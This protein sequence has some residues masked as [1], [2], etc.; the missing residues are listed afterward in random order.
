VNRVIVP[1]SQWIFEKI[2]TSAI[3]QDALA[4]GPEDVLEPQNR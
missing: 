2:D 4:V 3:G 1:A